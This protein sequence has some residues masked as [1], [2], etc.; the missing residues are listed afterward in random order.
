[1]PSQIG[2]RCANC[3]YAMHVVIESAWPPKRTDIGLM[4]HLDPDNK[5]FTKPWRGCAGWKPKE[6]KQ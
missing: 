5:Q 1:M 2:K 4:C 3:V 6:V